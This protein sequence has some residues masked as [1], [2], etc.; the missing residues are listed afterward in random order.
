MKA[1]FT[2]K[3]RISPNL[4]DMLYDL[5]EQKDFIDYIQESAYKSSELILDLKVANRRNEKQMMYAYY[6]KVILS[7][8]IRG[9]S[10]LGYE[11][12]DKVKADYLLKAEC[13]KDVMY[14]SKTDSEVIFLED[15]AAMNKDRLLKFITDCIHFIEIELGVRVPD[16]D[17][18][19]NMMTTGISGFKSTHSK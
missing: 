4:R 19:K 3:P 14:N 10:D 6:H 18:Y 16:A 9:F 2:F 17:E 13:A 12:M 1:T 8:A 11:A 5:V 7:S 15:K